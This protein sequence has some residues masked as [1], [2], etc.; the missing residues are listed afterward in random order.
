MKTTI[1]PILQHIPE[2]DSLRTKEKKDESRSWR[3]VSEV[4]MSLAS[5]AFGLQWQN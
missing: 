2:P 4:K 3:L 5:A 1:E